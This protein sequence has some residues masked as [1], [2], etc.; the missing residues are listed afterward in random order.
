MVLS[1]TPSFSVLV[2]IYIYFSTFSQVSYN[3]N[4]DVCKTDV[5]MK[6][7]STLS[8]LNHSCNPSV[9][10]STGSG[11]STSRAIRFI[12]AGQE[13]T[14][15]YGITYYDLEKSER[16]GR[17]KEYHFTCCCEACENNWPRKGELPSKLL[18]KC[19]GCSK[20]VSCSSGKCTKC[21]K[22]EG[23]SGNG[24]GSNLRKRNQEIGKQISDAMKNY[25]HV[26]NSERFLD[27]NDEKDIEVI[28]KVIE[29]MDKY[30]VLPCKFYYDAQQALQI[31]YNRERKFTYVT[32]G[33]E[34][35]LS[36]YY[37]APLP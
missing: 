11:T 22:D 28:S 5:G 2:V 21:D 7:C 26:R 29:L 32:S 12:P 34:N 8:L 31:Y 4:R 13:V 24:D 36:N 16:W 14:T 35:M 17:L 25:H 10:S 15:C 1:R 6:L 9:Y 19:V 23:G 27:R 33:S 20:P 18:M 3:R 30:V 37:W